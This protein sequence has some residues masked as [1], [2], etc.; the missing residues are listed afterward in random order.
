MILITLGVMLVA[1]PTLPQRLMPGDTV[2]LV[3]PAS[4]PRDPKAVDLAVAALEKMGF[5]VR[6]GRHTRDRH[7]FIAGQDRERAADVM[8]AFM[9]GKVRGI[10]CLRGGYGTARMASLLDYQVIREN[11]KVFAGYSDVTFLHC[12]LL[13]KSRLLSFHSPMA[14]SEFIHDDFPE[15]SRASFMNLVTRTE[16]Y[17]SICRGY[18]GGT[19]SILA[20]GSV[21]GELIGGNL[22]VLCTTIGT[23][24]EPS[25][26]GKIL[27]LEDLDEKPYR[28]D[29]MLTHLLNAG[30]LGLVAGIAI[31]LCKNCEDPEAKPGGEFRQSLDDVFRERLQ[32]LG[33]PVVTGLPFGHGKYNATLPVG[34][35][36]TL[37]AVNGDLVLTSA[38]VC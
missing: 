34:G 5:P 10:I 25:F 3:A 15:F 28:V 7:G 11:P 38:A 37:D 14:A 12:A 23:E 16:P 18:E 17:G 20:P 26:R 33:I 8:A 32:P 4:A 22:T 13:K 35:R 36:A 1:M 19:V 27:F 24:F 9:D 31:G 30:I 2:G 21:S 29:R 6:L